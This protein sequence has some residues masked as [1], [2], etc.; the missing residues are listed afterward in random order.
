[1]KRLLSCTSS[2]MLKM[3]SLSKAIGKTDKVV[4]GIVDANFSK[5]MLKIINGGEV[6]G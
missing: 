6:I 5:E 2:E 4:V 3:E 1:M